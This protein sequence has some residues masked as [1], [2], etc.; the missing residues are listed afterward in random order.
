MKQSSLF[1]IRAQGDGRESFVVTA[2]EPEQETAAYHQQGADVWAVMFDEGWWTS[3]EVQAE[4]G[5]RFGRHWS[6]A[7]IEARRRDFRKPQF[8]RH[9]VHRRLRRDEDGNVVSRG[10]HEYRLAESRSAP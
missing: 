2:D 4:I 8:G 6:I 3:E 9:K 1:D 10:L 7:S 5:R